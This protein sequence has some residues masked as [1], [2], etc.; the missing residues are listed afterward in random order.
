MEELDYSR[1]QADF[2][3]ALHQRMRD[4][5]VMPINFDVI[6]DIDSGTLPLG[7]FIR[8]C[9]QWGQRRAIERLELGAAG[10]G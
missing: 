3:L 6:I 9:G 7:V 10:A 5:V 4:A 2:D 8:L 1:S